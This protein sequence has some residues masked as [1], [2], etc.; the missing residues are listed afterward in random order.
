M[1]GNY[2][3]KEETGEM[4][5]D[6]QGNLKV[7][8]QAGAGSGGT[9][10]T[11]D[12]AFTAG[13]GSG[14]PMMGFVTADTVDSGDVGVVGMLAN[15]Q[16][17]VTLYD[18]A[19]AELSVGGGTQY[20]E[21]AASAANPTGT[22]PMLIRQDTPASEV[23]TNGD[24]IAQR[25]TQYGAAYTQIV[26]STGAFIDTFGGG[27]QYTEGDTDASITG[28]A[29]MMEGAGNALVVAQ[30]TVADGLLVNLGANND[31]TVTGTVTANLA[32]GT[33]NIG[34]VDVLSVPAPLSTTGGGTEATALRV[35]IASDSTGVVSI[36][37][38]GSSITVDG[39]VTVSATNLDIRDLVAASD[40][41]S[42]HGD[43]G[44]IDQLDLTNSNPAVVAIVDANGDQITSFGGGTQ[45]TEDAAAAANPVGTVPILIR[46]DTPA[47][48]VSTNG[49]NIA[50]RANAYGGAYV[51]VVTSTGAFVDTFGGG[52]Q[53][54]EDAASAADPVGTATILVRADTPA[55]ITST[56]GDNVAWRGNNFG[57]AYVQIM[58]GAAKASIDTA[59]ADNESN[60]SSRLNVRSH[61]SYYDGSTW[62]RV[63]GDST[64]GLLV[65]LGAN[66]DVTVS[67][68]STAANQTTI[69]G[70]LDGVEGLLTTI[71]A[72]TGSIATSSSAIQTAV[73]LLDDSAVVLG[74]ATYT[75]AASTGL[76]IGAVRRDADTTLVNTTNEWGPLQMDANGRLK[77]EAFSGE[78]LP[79]S[80]T[81]TTITGTV[82]VDSEL[83]TAAALADNTANPTTTSVGVFPHWYDGSTWDRALGNST[84]GL[85]VNLGANND[86]TVTGT[87]TANL[88]AGTNNIGDVDVLSVVPGTAATN[89]GKAVD[90]AGG[91][92]DTGVASLVIRDDALTTLTPVDG[93]YVNQ[94]GNA[95][96]ATWVA[97][98]DGAGGQITSF[99]GG[100][101]VAEDSA[102]SSGVLGGVT[103]A[104]R[105]DTPTSLAGTDNDYIPLTTDANGAAWVSLATKLDSTNDAVAIGSRTTGGAS[106]FRS[107]DLDETEEEVK[108]SAGTV[109][110]AW[111]TNTATSTRWLKFYNATAAS[112]SVG[113]TTPVITIGIPG[114]T[115]D[116]I[117]G[118]FG[119]P[120]Q[121]VAFGTA[122]TVAATT[123]VADSDTGAPA[124]NDVIVNIFYA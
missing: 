87:V 30:G 65:N 119:A 92:T 60:T 35:T 82:T 13:S 106:I 53:Y 105:R 40:A 22:V 37:D 52:T 124:A 111:V 115:S 7:N 88:A 54:T 94:R 113:T 26:S 110:G 86:V 93:D 36:D 96:G 47:S 57:E 116:D 89:L 68:V 107:L 66:N 118:Y 41:V 100:T 56:D 84:D 9:S 11:D 78:T 61:M 32:A 80:L 46:Q 101:E 23:S 18:S 75:E 42:I 90:S 31:V 73:Q 99:G 19:G 109:Y 121:G 21:D 123:G 8:I 112:V 114:N 91:A 44:I 34:D 49:D 63:R 5:F 70:H 77:V 76:A 117:S 4:Q 14:T 15:R 33:N 3:F 67:G 20:T 64:D 38:N 25:A 122:I 71:D 1:A 74:T 45:Y 16:L 108:A 120:G 17:K 39:S 79:V 81:S 95:R 97:I 50:Q 55:T 85:L 103:M 102:H 48:E 51:Q 72:D 69:I 28:T 12:A 104:V 43:V 24:N 83:P 2:N 62:D 98:E 29:M 10:A 59:G 6:A 58:D 27:T